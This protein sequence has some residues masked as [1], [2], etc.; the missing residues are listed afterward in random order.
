[1]NGATRLNTLVQ[2]GSGGVQGDDMLG[3]SGRSEKRIARTVT[4]NISRLDE[5][6]LKETACTEN[7][8]PRGAR[9]VTEREWQPGSLVL[10]ISPKDG[11]RS[12]AQIVYCQ[13]LGESRF[14]VGLELSARLEQWGKT[15]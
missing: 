11:V 6:S 5:P 1:M 14:A 9:V 15:R 3:L 10:F 12:E 13:H 4:V 8:S 2:R 7:I